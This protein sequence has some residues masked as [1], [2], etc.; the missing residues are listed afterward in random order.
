MK[1]PK[2]NDYL[3]SR[4]IL[5]DVD[6]DLNDPPG[7]L[8]AV[9]GS[10]ASSN[11]FPRSGVRDSGAGWSEGWPGVRFIIGNVLRTRGD[12]GFLSNTNQGLI[13]ESDETTFRRV[14]NGRRIIM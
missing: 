2:S 7:I 4:R 14:R 12:T 6:G 13:I 11:L 8:Y 10:S 5:K 1:T 9:L 3:Q